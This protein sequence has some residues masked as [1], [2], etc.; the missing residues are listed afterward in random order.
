[1]PI[2][3]RE[4]IRALEDLED[5]LRLAS[6]RLRFNL[7]L[8]RRSQRIYFATDRFGS[9]LREGTIVE[10]LTTTT[11]SVREGTIATILKCCSGHG[12]NCWCTVKI[13]SGSKRRKKYS[14]KAKNL[15]KLICDY[16]E[17]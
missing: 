15:R 14:R 13:W 12:P 1:M 3:F 17:I 9:V 6:S 16:Y 4:H 7:F 11:A 10:I 5:R 2:T 8:S